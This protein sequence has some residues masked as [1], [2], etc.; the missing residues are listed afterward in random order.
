MIKYFRK[1][2]QKLLTENK[3]SKYLIYAIGIKKNI[4][5]ENNI[6]DLKNN[7]KGSVMILRANVKGKTISKMIIID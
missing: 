7:P 1:V 6:I 3:F 2:R 5:V 4:I